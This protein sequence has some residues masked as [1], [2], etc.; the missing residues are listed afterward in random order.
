MTIGVLL[1]PY[2]V[3]HERH[4]N[5]PKTACAIASKPTMHACI[6]IITQP[7]LKRVN[8]MREIEVTLKGTFAQMRAK[9]CRERGTPLLALL[10]ERLAQALENKPISIRFRTD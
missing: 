3:L 8:K 6:Y 5:K 4:F 7:F 9:R 10:W 2:L 1:F